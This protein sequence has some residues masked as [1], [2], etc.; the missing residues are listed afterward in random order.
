MAE[1]QTKKE[2]VS[3]PVP[4]PAEPPLAEAPPVDVVDKKALAPPPSA[5]EET[6]ALAVVENEKTPVPVQKKATGGS[7]DRDIALAEIEKEKRLSNVKA[8]EE[9]EK[10]KANNKAQKQ[11]SS[12]AA[13]ENSKKAAIEAQLRK[14]EEQLEKKKAE[15]GEKMKNKIAMVH[16]Q[17]EEKRAIVEA[18]RSEEILKAEEMA[19][20]YNATR[21]T[22]KK[23]LGCF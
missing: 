13:W 18:K 5:A 10:T 4:A 22:P 19:A 7:L 23:L 3:V 6:K 15:Y 1:L 9:S 8:W 20:K 21:T 14:I 11:L 16:K 17:A 2:T 12:V